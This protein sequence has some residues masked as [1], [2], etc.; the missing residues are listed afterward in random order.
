VDRLAIAS[1][2]SFYFFLDP[3]PDVTT[4]IL[5]IEGLEKTRVNYLVIETKTLCRYIKA[6]TT[7]R[8]YLLVHP[9]LKKS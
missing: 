2:D 8:F 1:A 4:E 7:N 9:I 5:S 3:D 6:S